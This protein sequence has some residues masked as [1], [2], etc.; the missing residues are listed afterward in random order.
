MSLARYR[1]RTWLAAALAMAGS[2]TALQATRHRPEAG[3]VDVGSIDIA[4]RAQVGDVLFRGTR[5]VE[6]RVVR[7]FDSAS[8]YTHVGVLV[9]H[10]AEPGWAVVHASSD[11]RHVTLEPLHDYTSVDGMVAAGLYRWQG[12]ESAALQAL[13]SDALATVGRPFDGAFDSADAAHLYCTELVWLLAQWR[14]WAG[15]PV[16]KAIAT[17][18]G[19]LRVVT[20][21]ALLRELPLQ[22]V[23]RSGHA[24][25]QTQ[26]TG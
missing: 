26:S 2:V 16:L 4:S 22:P 18:L 24:P 17:P 13:Q 15:A 12:V 11:T 3:R 25:F 9:R 6:G 23:W 8:D 20:I 1:R 14:G 5:S 10:P 21:D 7:W 19:G